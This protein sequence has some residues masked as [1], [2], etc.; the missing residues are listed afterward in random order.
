MSITS[1]EYRFETNYSLI[2]NA[3]I[4]DTVSWT[5]FTQDNITEFADDFIPEFELVDHTKSW[6]ESRRE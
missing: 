6:A 5:I 3:V 2:S 4:I 1:R